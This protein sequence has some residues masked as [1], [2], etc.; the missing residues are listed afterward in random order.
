MN[1]GGHYHDTPEAWRAEIGGAGGISNARALAKMFTPL[2]LKD[3][4]LL[5]SARIEDMS[6]PCAATQK[7]R[8]LMVPTRFGQGFM[9]NMDNRHS[10]PGDGN[11]LIIGESAF[12]HVGAGGSIGFADP[13][14][15]MAFGYSM[16]KMG[17]G[18]LLNKRGQGL[19][20]A[21]YAAL[22]EDYPKPCFHKI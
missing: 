20:D 7:D 8:T 13:D 9:L 5:S 6:R 11:S 16:T 22:G 3:G 19:V 18:I 1:N 4:T 17:A 14:V 21:A 15:R 12:G 10:H 2:A